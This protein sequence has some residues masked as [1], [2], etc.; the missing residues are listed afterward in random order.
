MGAI[1]DYLNQTGISVVI[2]ETLLAGKLNCTKALT[3]EGGSAGGAT[4]LT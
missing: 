3:A 2:P 1:L 4:Q